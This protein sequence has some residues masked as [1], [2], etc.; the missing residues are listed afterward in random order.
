MKV[1]VEDPFCRSQGAIADI[2]A[3]LSAATKPDV[4]TAC[5]QA[6]LKL[7]TDATTRLAITDAHGTAVICKLL[8]PTTPQ[9]GHLYVMVLASSKSRPG[10][11]SSHVPDLE[12]AST[13]TF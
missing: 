12:Q 7:A 2:V 9:V 5:L 11:T 4:L 10:N 8:A 3:I 13:P 1:L 6:L